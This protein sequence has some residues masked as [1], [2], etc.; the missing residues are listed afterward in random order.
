MCE[1]GNQETLPELNRHHRPLRLALIHGQESIPRQ[2]PPLKRHER[3]GI[4]SAT[5]H[6]TAALAADD[7]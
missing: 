1:V 6:L 4:R 2:L 5:D 7:V 3:L